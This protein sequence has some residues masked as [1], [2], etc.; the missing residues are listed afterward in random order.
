MEENFLVNVNVEGAIYHNGKFLLV[1]RSEKEIHASGDLALVGG[2]VDFKTDEANILE[3]TLKREIQE[4]VGIEV[5]DTMTYIKSSSF[6]SIDGREFVDIVFLCKYKSG[7][8]KAMSEEVAN[9]SWMSLE[10]A[11]SDPRVKPW[12]KDSLQKASA[13][14]SAF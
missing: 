6:T 11:L 8:P 7:Q 5:E 10:E 9:V 14:V 4:E 13:L 2:K 1:V 12:T 3:H